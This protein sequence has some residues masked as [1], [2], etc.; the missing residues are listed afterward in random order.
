MVSSLL[1]RKEPSAAPD[2]IFSGARVQELAVSPS[3][4]FPTPI[5]LKEEDLRPEKLRVS[6]LQPKA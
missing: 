2:N 5:T 6:S 1:L 3:H 4:T